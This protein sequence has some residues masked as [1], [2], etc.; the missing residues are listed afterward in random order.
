MNDNSSDL[1]TAWGPDVD[2]DTA[3]QF[4]VSEVFRFR[5]TL[6]SAG[7]Q[8]TRD[9]NITVGCWQA[10]AV[11]RDEAMTVATISR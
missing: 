3:F 4:L 11:I 6:L 1:K 5:G 9:L 8:A 10:M 2:F 7:E